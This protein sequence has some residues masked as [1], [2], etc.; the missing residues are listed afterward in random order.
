E[1]ELSKSLEVWVH[2]LRLLGYKAISITNSS[3]QSFTARPFIGQRRV[4]LE[5]RCGPI[6][7]SSPPQEDLKALDKQSEKIAIDLHD[8]IFVCIFLI[9]VREH[10]FVEV[11]STSTVR[12]TS[13]RRRPLP[14]GHC[15]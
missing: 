6:E 13:E 11:R 4:R 8:A 9:G 15:V 14:V 2:E 10:T 5:R 3:F 1:L 12:N 7:S